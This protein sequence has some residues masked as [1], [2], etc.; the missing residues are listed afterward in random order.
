MAD[1]KTVARPYAEAIFEYAEE[2]GLL[3]EVSASLAPARDMLSELSRMLENLQRSRG[4]VFSG[5]VLLELARHGVSREQ[6][7][8]W[9]Q[10]NAMRSFEE[11]QDFKTLLLADPDVTGVLSAAAID[12]AFDLDTQMR[13]VETIF[14][15]VCG[16]EQS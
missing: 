13:H 15:R 11:Q 4:V 12:E 14:S 5:S 8:A 1:N 3:D 16:G 7:Y 9:V 2:K 6:A 10:R